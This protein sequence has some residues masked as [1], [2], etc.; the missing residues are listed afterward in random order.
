MEGKLELYGSASNTCR[1]D[2][3]FYHYEHIIGALTY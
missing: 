3:D 1:A 2:L